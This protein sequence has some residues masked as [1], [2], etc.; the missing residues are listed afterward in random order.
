[1][2]VVRRTEIIEKRR[3]HPKWYFFLM[4]HVQWAIACC[5]CKSQFKLHVQN[6]NI[7]LLHVQNASCRRTHFWSSITV[8]WNHRKTAMASE[9][10]FFLSCARAKR[11][12]MLHVQNTS[13]IARAKRKQNLGCTCKTQL[14]KNRISEG[15]AVFLTPC[16]EV[17]PSLYAPNVWPSNR[18]TMQ[19]RKFLHHYLKFTEAC[20]VFEKY[21]SVHL[22][23]NRR[24]IVFCPQ[25]IWH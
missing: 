11:N 6:A 16:S 25:K 3:W 24:E 15:I 1:M 4:M 19:S 20:K 8:V 5:T 22:F 10:L 17:R 13:E 7:F 9:T 14:A 2:T 12:C 23:E 18:L 21:Q